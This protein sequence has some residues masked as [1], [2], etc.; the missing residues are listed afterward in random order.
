MYSQTLVG[1]LFKNT[2]CHFSL[3]LGLNESFHIL[4]HKLNRK[5][6]KYSSLIKTYKI[7]G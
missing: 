1:P 4:K 2:F 6:P 7:D 3:E 5:T